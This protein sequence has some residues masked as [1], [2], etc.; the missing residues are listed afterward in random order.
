MRSSLLAAALAAATL[1]AADAGAQPFRSDDVGPIVTGSGVAGAGFPGAA[2]RDLED[3]LFRQVGGRTVFR[4]RAVADA[5]LARGAELGEAACRGALEPPRR[6]PPSIPLDTAAQR[7]VCGLL[8]RPGDSP[9]AR[10]VRAALG[11]GLPGPHVEAADRL[12]EALAGLLAA[13]REPADARERWIA[14]ERWERAFAAYDAYLAAAPGA[15]LDPPPA[16]LA[17]AGLV[18]QRLVEAGLAASGR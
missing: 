17:V 7:V 16:E 2:F 3:A 11:G 14:A 5:V 1:A 10:R 13:P 15:L 9:E 4:S 18:L 6:W 12:T 8:L